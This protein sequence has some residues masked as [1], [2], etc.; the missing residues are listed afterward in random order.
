MDN[1]QNHSLSVKAT[2]PSA[3]NIELGPLPLEDDILPVSRADS[4]IAPLPAAST[5]AERVTAAEQRRPANG[6]VP[7]PSG[8]APPREIYSIHGEQ[9][10]RRWRGRHHQR[11]RLARRVVLGLPGWSGSLAAAGPLPCAWHTVVACDL[12]EQTCG[13]RACCCTRT[14][15]TTAAVASGWRA[16]DVL[17]RPAARAA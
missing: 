12:F 17:L 9:V 6:A 1:E 8:V 4:E 5:L 16:A 7:P 13:S 2:S 15:P 11:R 10:C 14:A 3:A